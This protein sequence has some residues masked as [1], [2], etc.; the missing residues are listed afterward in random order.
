MVTRRDFL[1]TGAVAGLVLAFRLPSRAATALAPNAF[2]SVGAD[3][4]VTVWV[5]ESE[6]GQGVRT[7]LPMLV[8]EELEVD[9]SAVRVEQASLD[10]AARFGDA[11]TLTGGSR[12]V[13]TA[14]EPLRRAGATAREMLVETASRA[15][16]VP[17]RE[18]R[19]ERGAVLGPGD[20]RAAYGDLVAAAAA[21]PVPKQE[22][23]PL[24]EPKDFKLLGTRVRRLDG[25]DIVT[26]R[27]R[28]GLD[29]RVAGM[30]VATIARCPVV[31]GSVA[32]VDD[33]KAKAVPG[34][35]AVVSLDNGSIDYGERVWSTGVAVVA[36]STWSALAG[37]EA[38]E[39]AWNDGKHAGLD[40]ATIRRELRRAADDPGLYG[41]YTT[42][43]DGD[44]R[45]TLARAAR[46]VEAVYEVPYLAHAPLETM[47]C[48][49]D[50]HGDRC[51]VW[52]PTQN[53]AGARDIAAEAL[54]IPKENVTIH[55]ALVG[56]GFGR[57]LKNDYVAEA[58]LVSK[59][60]GAP[61]QLVWTRADETR[62]GF[63]RP[64][65]LHRFSVALGE[66]GLPAAWV[67][68]VVGPSGDAFEDPRSP[69]PEGETFAANHL[70]YGVPEVR[71]EYVQVQAPVPL[72]SW[73]SVDWSQ[74]VFVTESFL[75][76]LALAARV[77]PVALR[78]RLLAARRA[79]LAE[80]KPESWERHVTSLER[81]EAALDLA[82]ERAGW[83]TALPAGRG[84]GVA[85]ARGQGGMVAQV[86]EVSV[87]AGRVRVHRVVV[88]ID[89]GFA[90]NPE[91]IEAQMEGSVAFALS[92]TLKG[93]IT[94]ERGRVV[95]SSYRDYDVVRIDEMPV[96]ETHIVPSTRPPG[97][98]GEPAVPPVAA[99]VTNALFAATGQR[100][101]ELP[102][103]TTQSRPR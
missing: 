32:R 101:R 51:E 67:H 13:A 3:N 74:T 93:E 85:I 83:G 65:S 45:A 16:G 78:K 62:H 75:D 70:P 77:D 97:G 63:Y 43:E 10:A 66:D 14:W 9:L 29:T 84:R 80:R 98:V 18:C 56:G 37:R 49:A 61:V 99:A 33:T 102:I 1:K 95:Q 8:A 54:G 12:S 73:R 68:R 42:R 91:T 4:R 55:V 100:I 96:V 47:N 36:E 11:L 21:L 24:K 22:E 90:V 26:G 58:A 27:A 34:V 64:A 48:V 23:V 103:H 89:C 69:H 41:L 50:V 57:R 44:A 5:T 81:L 20:R 76:E 72:G 40:S 88:A 38:L 87:E 82:A 59:A 19:A 94:I 79:Q 15:W 60:A 46:R 17:K 71:V 31:G 52:A 39:I 7:S 86:A 2:L 28:Y 6:M 30:L 35:R 92:A 53:P 25:P